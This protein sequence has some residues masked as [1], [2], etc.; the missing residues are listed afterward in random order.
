MLLHWVR[1]KSGISGGCGKSDSFSVPAEAGIQGFDFSG[2]PF[3]LE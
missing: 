3:L 1:R 2:F